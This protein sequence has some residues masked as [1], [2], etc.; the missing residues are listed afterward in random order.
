MPL[1]EM[2]VVKSPERAAEPMEHNPGE[3]VGAHIQKRYGKFHGHL[4]MAD[5]AKHQLAPHATMMEAHNAMHEHIAA[6]TA[7]PSNEI[8]NAREPLE[9]VSD[10]NA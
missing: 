4:E 2:N 10:R 6:N 8:Q 9:S 5:G 3:I 1:K 7:E